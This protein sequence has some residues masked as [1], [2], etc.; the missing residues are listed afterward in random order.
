MILYMYSSPLKLKL[1]AQQWVR[2][3]LEQF[4]LQWACA[5]CCVLLVSACGGSG[6]GSVDL[7]T[8]SAPVTNAPSPG[9]VVYPASSVFST[10]YEY[11][12]NAQALQ[13]PVVSVSQ[14]LG[15]TVSDPDTR[16]TVTFGD[17]FRE[18][19][20]HF[21][22]FVMVNTPGGQA[23][24]HFFKWV[25]SLWVDQTSTILSDTSGCLTAAF[26]ITA[27]FNGDGRHDVLV[28]CKGTP[29]TGPEAQILYL[30]D[31]STGVYHKIFLHDPS[32]V[33]FKWK[34]YQ[35]AAA[36][37]NA[38]GLMD[39]VLVDPTQSQP[40]VLLG[41]SNYV[42]FDR[43][44]S[45]NTTRVIDASTPMIPTQLH[46][47]QIIPNS[48]TR[49]NMV[50][51]G[52]VSNGYPT[53][54]MLGSPDTVI[55]NAQAGTFFYGKDPNSKAFQIA[56]MEASDVLYETGYYYLDLQDPSHTLMR[57]ARIAESTLS[58]V[59]PTMMIA[60]PF[61]DGVSLK[62]LRNSAGVIGV[63][64]GD[65]LPQPLALASAPKSRCAL[66]LH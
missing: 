28:T 41:N 16:N 25:N 43:S 62:I 58:E 50:L 35:A 61:S 42:N 63:Y 9:G 1:R 33:P 17:Y 15:K 53:L 5:M 2:P 44:F 32:G 47:V 66:A 11:K 3:F 29:S 12:Q 18:G 4:T 19:V 36:D 37:I 40:L 54:L 8:S 55:S 7:G 14:L 10:S 52:A 65:C 38:D 30:S 27:D 48:T 31:N 20:G 34:A 57:V 13:Y 46:G 22:A 24:A 64:D 21:S 23:V 60:T 26:A 45:L 6:G 59:L 39:V 56:A 49:L 51:M